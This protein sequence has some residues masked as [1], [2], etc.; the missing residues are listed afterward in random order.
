[1]VDLRK[2]ARV[3]RDEAAAGT[4]HLVVLTG[5]A[6]IE[7]ELL[8]AAGHR[9]AAVAVNAVVVRHELEVRLA[10]V[11]LSASG[12][13]CVALV[14]P[15]QLVGLCPLR[16]GAQSHALVGVLA[17]Q[18]LRVH[19]SRQKQLAHG[20]GRRIDARVLAQHAEVA[21]RGAAAVV[22]RAADLSRLAAVLLDH[23]VIGWAFGNSV[24]A[25]GA[26]ELQAH[27]AAVRDLTDVLDALVVPLIASVAVGVVAARV[28]LALRQL[29][30]AHGARPRRHAV[31]AVALIQCLLTVHDHLRAVLR[32]DAAEHLLRLLLW[33]QQIWLLGEEELADRRERVLNGHCLL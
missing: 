9:F 3:I 11:P 15:S 8:I 13:I 33:L 24:L 23:F 28:R 19:A 2:V 30:L 5:L 10:V 1:M 21:E 26:H 25:R 27:D 29:A 32:R 14:P 31:L 16:V 20:R 6:L 18:A 17:V 12:P 4:R 22:R 7:E